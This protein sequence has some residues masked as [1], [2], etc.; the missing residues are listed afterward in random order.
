MHFWA[1]RI[2]AICLNCMF[3]GFLGGS[4]DFEIAIF[5]TVSLA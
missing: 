5:L 3:F 4:C 1:I 2:E